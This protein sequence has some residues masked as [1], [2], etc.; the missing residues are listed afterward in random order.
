MIFIDRQGEAS[1]ALL[2]AL[3]GTDYVPRLERELELVSGKRV[4]AVG[5]FDGGMHTALSLCNVKSGDYVFAPTFTFYSY[6]ASITN[7][8]ALPVFLD[9][10]PTTR[11]VSPLALEAALVWAGLQNKPPKAVV[12]DNAFGSYADYDKLV[13]LCKAWNVPTIEICSGTACAVACDYGVISLGT[14]GGGAVVCGDDYTKARQFARYEYTDGENHDYRLNNY[15]AALA[16]AFVSVA[17]KIR[18]RKKANLS[19]LV[20][21]VDCIVPPAKNDSADYALCKTD[22][23]KAIS[24]AGFDVLHP[25]LV[26]TLSRYSGCQFFEHEQGYSVA[27]SLKGH[28]LIDMDFS[29][30]RR[31]KLIAMLKEN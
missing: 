13:P 8:K 1:A 26:H 23:Y 31:F 2:D 6:L 14:D 24:A 3:S 22:N 28:V 15:S 7:I 30:L 27:G 25:P 21:A 12:I 11:C 20:A 16:C 10:D 17:P 18:E 9:C 4:V 19:A 29:P 5:T